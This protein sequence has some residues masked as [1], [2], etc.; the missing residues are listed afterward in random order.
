MQEIEQKLT[1]L[2]KK[3]DSLMTGFFRMGLQI[4]LIFAV[5]AAIGVILDKTLFADKGNTFI[6][7]FLA[8][9]FVLSW[10][11]VIRMYRIQSKK[12]EAIESQ[13]KELKQNLST[14]END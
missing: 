14:K 9:S 2:R 12:V 6:S 8:C 1:D 11:I 3:R 5:P 7:V 13:I 10:M 4:A